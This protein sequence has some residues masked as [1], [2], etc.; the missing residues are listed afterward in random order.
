MR[1][2]IP[3]RGFAMATA[4][5]TL[6][7]VGALAIGTLF[8]ATHELRSGTNGIHQ[9]RA[10]T[11]A[12]LGLEQTIAV[13]NRSWNGAFAR[14]FGRS[15]SL[16]TA[17]GAHLTVRLTRLT[18][19]LFLVS[20]DARAGPA[21]RHIARV[22]RLQTGDPVLIGALTSLAVLESDAGGSVDGADRV[23]AG[24]DCPP[25][26]PP[27]APFAIS[28]SVTLLRFGQFDWTVLAEAATA[29]LTP[30]IVG[31]AP[32]ATDEECDTA[33]PENWGEPIK[34]NGGA[35]TSYYAIVHV[36]GDLIVD[37]GRGQ[38]LLIVDGDLTLRGGFEFFGVVLVRG[39]LHAG[40]GGARITGAVAL[41]AR[42]QTASSL[43]VIAIDFSRCAARKALL[44]LALPSPIVERSWYEVFDPQ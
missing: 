18:D 23:P 43:G 22:V 36:S 15:W 16:A 6:V 17:E 35:C 20:S 25:P 38:G 5:F 3:R 4:V 11:A 26:G 44:G 28:D 34:S 41:A 31:P 8:A 21:R 30:G 27:I 24:W 13:W 42:Y 29:H 39:A 14:G 10:V 7:V 9:A 1:V 19:E 2:R 37:G 33:V 32:R 40:V 12:E